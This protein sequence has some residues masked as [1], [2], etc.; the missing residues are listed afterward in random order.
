M[1]A[2]GSPGERVPRHVAIIMD[3]NGRWAEARGLP[4]TAGHE[5][6]VSSVRT[7]T[8]AC[9]R[10]GVEALTL[11]SFSSENWQRPA[12]EVA[13]L[14][15]LLARYLHEERDE[16]L[17]NGIRLRASGQLD[18]LPA[19]VKGAL[20]ALMSASSGQRGMVLNLALSYGGRQE[21]VAAVRSI[22][23]LARRGSLRVEDIDERVFD[24][25]LST[26]GL[27]EPDLLIRTGGESRLSNFLLWQSAYAELHVSQKPWP[28]FGESDLARA[29]ADF[30]GRERRFGKTGAQIRG[31]A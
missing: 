3:G 13:A 16:L 29:F 23:D 4:R 6:G 26:A 27:P 8:R 22:A 21:I 1:P 24:S 30:A 20:D 14:M 7:V 25:H 31:K 18:R 9:R 15:Q 28:D 5:A 11:Y 10:W 19:F 2:A 17:G 12:A